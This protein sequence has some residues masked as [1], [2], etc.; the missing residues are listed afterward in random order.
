MNKLVTNS[1]RRNFALI[2]CAFR[3]LL[4]RYLSPFL[5][6]IIAGRGTYAF[7]V[8]PID[9]DDHMR[10]FPFASF[11]PKVM[12]HYWSKFQWPLIGSQI[13]GLTTRYGK[14]EMGW[15]I[16][17]PLSPRQMLKDKELARKRVLQ[18]VRLAEKLGAK[19]VG[20]GG[21]TSIVTTD[22]QD[23]LGKV[24]CSLTTGNAYAAVVAVDNVCELL[25]AVGKPVENCVVAVV[26]AA[27]SEGSACCKLLAGKVAR[28]ILVDKNVGGGESLTNQLAEYKKSEIEFTT[29]LDSIREADAVITVTNA[30]GAIVRASHLKP[31]AVVVDGAQPKNVSRHISNQRKDVLV[32][33][34]AIVETPGVRTNYKFDLGETEA[35]GCLAETQILIW[36]GHKGHFSLGKPDLKQVHD[37]AQAAK[38]AGYKL[39]PFRNSSGYVSK[40]DINRVQRASFGRNLASESIRNP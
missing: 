6:Q 11:I 31:G 28:L 37:I 17:C 22:G 10:Q 2:G 13:T 34:S 39:A 36:M 24:Q 32:V 16:V 25:R 18:S 5:A 3:D 19:V 35:L 15:V 29:K 33:D 21:F 7:I 1:L 23:L 26:G 12:R 9:F 14:Q 20:L 30:P 40:E 8:H 4:L 27:G 38:E